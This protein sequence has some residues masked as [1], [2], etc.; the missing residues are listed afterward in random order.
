MAAQERISAR[1]LA[2]KVDTRMR[3][4]VDSVE[5]D[6]AAARSPADAPEIDG[7]V[8]VERA[9]GLRPGCFVEV[10]VQRSD[11]HDLWAV[12]VST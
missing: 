9:A 12:P 5:G 8:H 3:V 11:A 10:T 6:R 7:V 1:R 4:L 2:R